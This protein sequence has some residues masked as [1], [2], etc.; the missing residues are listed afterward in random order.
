MLADRRAGSDGVAPRAE[1]RS[2][3]DAR[4]DKDRTEKGEQKDDEHQA[5]KNGLTRSS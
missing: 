5:A 2:A 1:T 4:G 3:H